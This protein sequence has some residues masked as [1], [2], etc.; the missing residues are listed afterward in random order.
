MTLQ[1]SR[2]LVRMFSLSLLP[3]NQLVGRWLS[4]CQVTING[5]LVFGSESAL[6]WRYVWTAVTGYDCSAP[7]D[8]HLLQSIVRTVLG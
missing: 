8:P 2:L 1:P 6:M 7:T 3:S 5:G 4:V